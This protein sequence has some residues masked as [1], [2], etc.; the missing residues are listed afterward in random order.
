M[1]VSLIKN[2][3]IFSKINFTINYPIVQ[4]LKGI[5]IRCALALLANIRQGSSKGLTLKNTP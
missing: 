1:Q 4:H 3:N 5:Q 2:F